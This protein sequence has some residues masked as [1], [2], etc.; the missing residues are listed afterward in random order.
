MIIVEVIGEDSPEM[1]L[2]EH[3]GMVKALAADRT[4]QAF[5]V[6]ILPRRSWCRDNFFDAHVLDALAEVH[7]IDAVAIS[8]QETGGLIVGKRLH[9]LLCCPLCCRVSRDVEVNDHPTVMTEYDKAEQDAKR[10]SRHREEIDCHDVANVVVQESPPRLRR[11]LAMA[12]PVL[13]HSCLRRIVAKESEFRLDSWSSPK[14]ILARHALNQLTDFGID[15]RATWFP[16]SRL[17]PPVQPKSLAMP[18]DNRLGL[19]DDEDGA[20]TRP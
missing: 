20:P 3:D 17:P 19:D 2:V 10:G 11:R 8:E 6:R 12:D 5:N 16:G 15:S 4:D 9:D 1:T 7:T 13:V 14:W 18:V